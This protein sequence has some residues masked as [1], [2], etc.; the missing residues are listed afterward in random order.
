MPCNDAII[1]HYLTTIQTYSS[2][3]SIISYITARIICAYCCMV[4][5]YATTIGVS[6]GSIVLGDG[7]I[8]LG[9][10]SSGAICSYSSARII[11]SYGSII[12]S[13]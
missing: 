10:G 11:F 12:I 3:G 6:K 2:V 1:C 7:S 5:F 13:Y 8:V 4:I 9:D